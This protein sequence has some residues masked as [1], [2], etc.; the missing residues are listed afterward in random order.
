[1]G[2]AGQVKGSSMHWRGYILGVVQQLQGLGHVIGG[3]NCVFGGDIPLGAGVS[4]SAA[5]ECATAFSLNEL[6]GLGV[7]P[8]A[9]GKVAQKAEDEFVGVPCGIMDQFARMFGR[10]NH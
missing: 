5:L 6:F 2:D 10:R 1:M 4:S 9:M 3:F 8:L 7:D